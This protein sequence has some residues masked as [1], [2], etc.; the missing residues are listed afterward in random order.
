MHQ[1]ALQCPFIHDYCGTCYGA[2]GV[3]VIDH[4]CAI[5]LKRRL[6]ESVRFP[7]AWIPEIK[8]HFTGDV[9][10]GPHVTHEPFDLAIFAEVNAETTPPTPLCNGQGLT[11]LVSQRRVL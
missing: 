9:I 11:G 4:S 2:F 7:L 3:E 1:H 8:G 5:M 10:F 6:V